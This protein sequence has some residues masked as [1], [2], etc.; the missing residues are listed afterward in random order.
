MCDFFAL[1]SKIIAHGEVQ[2]I[3]VHAE[4]VVQGL[5]GLKQ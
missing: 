3:V 5:E 4:I 2:I 1:R